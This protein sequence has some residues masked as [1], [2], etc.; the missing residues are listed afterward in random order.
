MWKKKNNN[1]NNAAVILTLTILLVCNLQVLFN[2]KNY[3]VSSASSWSQASARR[4]RRRRRKTASS[5]SS[6]SLSSPYYNKEFL[7]WTDQTNVKN[8][9]HMKQLIYDHIDPIQNPTNNT[10]L[11]ENFP[12][13]IVV[14]DVDDTVDDDEFPYSIH[15]VYSNLMGFSIRSDSSHFTTDFLTTALVDRFEFIT[16]IEEVR[17]RFRNVSHLEKKMC[18]PHRVCLCVSVRVLSFYH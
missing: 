7:V 14:N 2:K 1:N 6:S 4:R 9:Y 11:K 10:F 13:Y 18:A 12:E 16:T 8:K 5:E 17:I 15:Q 3:F